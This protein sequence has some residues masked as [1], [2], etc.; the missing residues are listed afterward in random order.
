MSALLISK[1]SFAFLPY[2]IIRM[3]NQ[4]SISPL[5]GKKIK[6]NVLGCR[7]N[8][9]ESEAIASAFEARGARVVDDPKADI[10]ILVSCAIT[11]MAEAKCRKSIR[12]MRKDSPNALIVACGCWPQIASFDDVRSAGAD[13]VVGNRVKHTIVDTVEDALRGSLVSC[14][15]SDDISRDRSWDA[16]SLDRPRS[17]TRAFIKVQ[18]G[19][20]M[21]C[22]YCIVP[23][24]R[25]ANVSRDPDDTVR[26]VERVASSGCREVV[27]TGIHLGSYRHG[28]TDLASLVRRV[29]AVNGISRVRLGSL[30]PF[31]V[32]RRLLDGLA[33]CGRFCEHLHLPLQSGDDGVLSSMRRGYTTDDFAAAV[34]ASRAALG[35]HVH[36]STDLMVGYPTETDTA[37]ENSIDFI[38]RIGI[39][40]VHVFPYSPR[41]GT[42][43]AE[44]KQLP[45]K[46]ISERTQRALAEAEALHSAFVR[47]CALSRLNE[48]VL[49]ETE[50][51]GIMY[52]WTRGYIRA[53]IERP[54]NKN[55]NIFIG[56][57]LSFNPKT[58]VGVIL[59]QDGE[60]RGRIRHFDDN[61]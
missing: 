27:L 43:A 13:I 9:Y 15:R 23:R 17:H 28:D 19:C 40:K 36:I 5:T 24:A 14:M 30:E 21:R 45:A 34:E 56:T 37:F 26:E 57:E 35:D 38:R 3:K 53:A 11:G 2:I 51:D 6:I 42:P 1:S 33:G 7:S 16:L 39:G 4:N 22:S 54:K 52:G 55:E 32:D 41:P 8:L 44:M 49:I 58:S 59:L 25:G 29:S 20:S 60:L 47:L 31:A 18:D 46:L 50:H 61:A 10:A 12:R 48:S